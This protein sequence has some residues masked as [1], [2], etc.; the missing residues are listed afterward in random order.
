MFTVLNLMITAYNIL[1]L[2]LAC[3]IVVKTAVILFT[4]MI[5]LGFSENTLSAT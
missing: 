5:Y 2:S 3:A 1:G 4:D